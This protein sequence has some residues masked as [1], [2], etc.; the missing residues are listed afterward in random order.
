MGRR[1][2]ARCRRTEAGAPR[3]SRAQCLAGCKRGRSGVLLTGL[4]PR[5]KR[6]VARRAHSPAH[7][8]WRQPRQ[9]P[10]YHLWCSTAGQAGAGERVPPCRGTL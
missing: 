1:V 2:Q 3:L 8:Q 4:R 10:G 7:R 9:R 6:G 5:H